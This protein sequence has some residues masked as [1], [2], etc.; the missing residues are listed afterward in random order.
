MDGFLTTQLLYVAAKLGVADV[1]AGGPRTGAEVAEAV[2]ADP[3]LLTRV[4][5]GL[6]LEDV[7]AEVD[8][9]RFALTEV[10]ERLRSDVPGSIKGPIVVRGELYYQAAAGM[11]A[12]VRHGGT[13]FEQVYGDR[14][15][16]Y[17]GRHPEQEAVFQGSMTGRSEQE[18]GDVVAAYDFGGLGRL[19]DVGGGYGIL[20]GTILRTAPD[21]RAVL[22]DQPA[23]VEQARRRLEADGVADR[24]QLVAGDFFASVPAEADAYLLSRVLHDWA[25]DDACRL[26]AACRSAMPTGSRLLV[27]EALLP[28]RAQDQPAVIRMDL[29]MLVLLGA[30]ERTEAQYRRLLAETGFQVERVV[31][32]RSPAGL[33]VIEA[34]PAPQPEGSTDRNVG[35]TCS[36]TGAR[37][38]ARSPTR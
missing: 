20:L 6:A 24:C 12:A 32:T 14:F 18:A 19:V 16:E 1:L 15:F 4:L 36:T 35:T 27:V 7:L 9:G 34:T 23:V 10:G 22:V 13:A 31:P 33:S 21:L 26:L 38:T 5:R 8:G 29:H 30:R 37:S 25:D 17:L 28:E 3:D 2:G 11:L